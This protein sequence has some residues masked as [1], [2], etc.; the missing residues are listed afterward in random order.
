MLTVPVPTLAYEPQAPGVAS[1]EQPV[2]VTLGPVLE[3]GRVLGA[4]DLELFGLLTSRRLAPGAA[5][6]TWS[7][8]ARSWQADPGPD[9][10]AVVDRVQPLAFLADR[11]APWQALVVAAG[12]TDASGAPVFVAGTGGHPSYGFAGV[13]RSRTGALA[14][15]AESPPVSFRSLADT[16]LVVVGPGQDQE[17]DQATQLRVLLRDAGLAVNGGLVL[18]R[19]AP[20]AGVRLS[21]AAGASVLLR[22]DGSLELRPAPGRR[23]E[24]AGDLETGRITYE[25]AGGGPKRVLT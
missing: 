11:P 23:V 5:P 17:P 19:G 15:G 10:A 24:V 1:L 9:T 20:G 7:A 13:F 3:E 25:P 8:A 6:Q 18:D 14:R 22:P 16:Q 2:T 12:M 21:N 4:P